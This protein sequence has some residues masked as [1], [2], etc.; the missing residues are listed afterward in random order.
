MSESKFGAEFPNSNVSLYTNW[1][2]YY[3]SLYTRVGKTEDDIEDLSSGTDEDR[4]PDDD[5]DDEDEENEEEDLSPAQIRR[6]RNV[7]MSSYTPSNKVWREYTGISLSVSRSVCLQNL[8]RRT[9][10]SA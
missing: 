3:K 2:A 6:L 9:P 1:V 10:P 7:S 4:P 5:D 8:V